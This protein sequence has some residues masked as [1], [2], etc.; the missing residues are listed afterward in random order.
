MAQEVAAVQ[1]RTRRK[2]RR[3]GLTAVILLFILILA[4]IVCFHHKDDIVWFDTGGTTYY[5]QTDKRWG[6]SLYGKEGTIAEAG[7]GPTC[8]A[9]V[10]STLTDTQV[11]P[12]DTA[13]WA[14]DNGQRCIGSGSYHSIIEEGGKA[15]G[16]TVEGA[17]KQHAENVKKA[18]QNGDLVVC[19]MSKGH[20]TT[21]GHFIMLRGIT[22][23]GK[24]L[25]SDP[26]SKKRSAEEWDFDII[27][28]EAKNGA[29][30]GGPFWICRKA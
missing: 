10:V 11:T 22:E 14:A 3:G 30:A 16:F 23:D 21:S 1:R 19:I 24:I 7:C 12:L 5:S 17:D 9:M 26:M 27:L 25:V 13:K 29:A 28:K 4:G 20:F 6:Q 15:Y 2:K 18:L 8:L